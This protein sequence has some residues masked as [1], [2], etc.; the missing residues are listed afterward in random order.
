ME[1]LINQICDVELELFLA[2]QGKNKKLQ[3][4]LQRKLNK[5]KKELDEK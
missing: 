1:K 4:Q 2:K 5:L 3:K